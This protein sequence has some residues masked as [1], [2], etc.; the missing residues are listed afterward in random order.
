MSAHSL[1]R[2]RVEGRFAR[3][4]SWLIENNATGLSVLLPGFGTLLIGRGMQILAT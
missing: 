1:A 4:K 3:W 2:Q